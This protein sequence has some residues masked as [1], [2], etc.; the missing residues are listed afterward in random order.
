MYCSQLFSIMKKSNQLS[1]HTRLGN[2]RIISCKLHP[3]LV[4]ILLD[5]DSNFRHIGFHSRQSLAAFLDQ[6]LLLDCK[7]RYYPLPSLVIGVLVLVVGIANVWDSIEMCRFA[8]LCL[9][10]NIVV[11]A[12]WS[13]DVLR[14]GRHSWS[15]TVMGGHYML[16]L[17]KFRF[18]EREE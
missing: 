13:M 7:S 9:F 14:V 8:S 15:F 17:L 2:T 6:S 5:L 11:D 3:F 12:W 16:L 10:R 18:R 1:Q 4:L